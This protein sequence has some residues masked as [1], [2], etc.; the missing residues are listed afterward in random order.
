MS[1]QFTV[2]P[3]VAG[4]TGLPPGVGPAPGAVAGTSN[5]GA[6][7]DSA[8]A[9]GT[10]SDQAAISPS[11]AGLDVLRGLLLYGAV[12]AFAGLYVY[13]IVRISAAKPGKPPSLDAT[14]VDAAAVL[15]GILGSAFALEIGV[16]P[17]EHSTNT[18]LAATLQRLRAGQRPPW[19]ARASAS[20]RTVLTF[21]PPST[22]SPSWPKTFGIWAYAIVASAV[23]IT[24]VVNQSETP[25]TI[26]TL[27]IAFAGYVLALLRSVYKSG[28]GESS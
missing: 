12:L 19:A 10:K 5:A 11:I 23:T 1:A 17:D 4:A 24:Y 6:G 21:D 9:D 8:V 25:G 26:K 27:A 2:P 3:G 13:F 7:G 16:P 14:M 20:I 28:G 22:Q 15:A 18:R